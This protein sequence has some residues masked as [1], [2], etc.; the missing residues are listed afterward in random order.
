MTVPTLHGKLCRRSVA[1]AVNAVAVLSAASPAS[2]ATA[3]KAV[4]HDWTI[5]VN[6]ASLHSV[7]SGGSFGYCASQHISALTPSITYSGAP[8]GQ[9]YS[10]KVIGP[11]AAGSIAITSVTNV[12]GDRVP[13]KF[14]SSSG[15]WDNT[16]AVMS[17]PGSFGH[18]T[19]PAGTY[20]FEVLIGGRA[21]VR[22]SVTLRARPAC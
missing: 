6:E 20:T 11:P 7:P 21:A 15:T 19:L 8:V 10:E 12:D 13:L 2:A 18:E 1:L 9:R 17:F 3:F 22:T 4:D 14:A 5:G 16:Y